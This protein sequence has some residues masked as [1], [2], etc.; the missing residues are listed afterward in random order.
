MTISTP[1]NT[2]FYIGAIGNAWGSARKMNGL[3]QDVAIYNT[4]LSQSEIQA[5]MASEASNPLPATTAVTIAANATSGP[6]RREPAGRLAVGLRPGQRRQHHQQQYGA[7]SVLTLSPT[8]GSTTFSGMIQGGGTLGA[9]SLV[10]SG[11]GT[12]VLAG[13]N[14]YTG[15]TTISAVVLSV[16]ILANGGSASGIGAS[17]ASPANLLLSGGILQYTA[18]RPARIASSRSARARAELTPRE[19]DH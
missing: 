16:G 19:Q 11:S 9:I 8:G 6:R 12:Q 14:T 2:A 5:L 1:S 7:A 15:G 17:S 10:M 13:S 18:L 3:I 4:S